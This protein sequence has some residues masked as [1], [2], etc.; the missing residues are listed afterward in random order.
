MHPFRC[1]LCGETYLGQTQP[2]RCPFC[3]ATGSALVKA[4]FWFDRGKVEMS[5]Q[6]YQNCTKSL[7]LE[8]NN[9]AF[10]RCAADKASNQL[11][12]TIFKRL[13][14][15]ELEH[16][17]LLSKAMGIQLPEMPAGTCRD[18]D[19][20]NFTVAHDHENTAINFYLQ[21]AAYATNA[22]EEEVSYILRHL[23]EIETEHLILTNLYK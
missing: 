23:S 8:L 7:E 15:Q 14:K 16:A 3:G 6:S 17:Q 5:R 1:Q 12:Q 22:G 9:A 13:F 21:T 10:Y 18:S 19:G 2:D 20:D 4:A 11:S